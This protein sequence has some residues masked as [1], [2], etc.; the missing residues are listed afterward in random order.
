M[1]STSDPETTY[2]RGYEFG[3]DLCL[4]KG[5]QAALQWLNEHPL[6]PSAQQS[7]VRSAIWDYE[8]ANGLA[9]EVAPF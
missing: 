7:G 4:T 1:S 3:R 2:A 6:A 5:M 8:D 9:H